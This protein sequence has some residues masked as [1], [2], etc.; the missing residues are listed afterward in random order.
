MKPR[1]LFLTLIACTALLMVRYSSE[2]ENR[3]GL[4][5]GSPKTDGKASEVDGTDSG[6]MPEVIVRL[7]QELRDALPD[8]QDQQQL[9]WLACN[10][11][12]T[13]VNIAKRHGLT[14]V[15]VILA[16]GQH[17]VAVMR[18][19]PDTF[20]KVANRLGGMTAA[21]FLVHLNRHFEEIAALGGLPK[22]LDRIESLPLEMRQLGT[23]HPEMLIFLACAPK[24]A[25]EALQEYPDL[26]LICFPLIDL[27][28]GPEPL[29][30]VAGM[31][32][33]HGVQAR[34]WVET[35][36]LDGMLLADTFPTVLDWKAPLDL[37]VFL[38][39][40]SNNQQDIQELIVDGREKDIQRSFAQL[41][42]QN[43]DLPP[44]VD[45]ETKGIRRPHRGD[46]LML[47]CVD[48]HTIRFLTES[49][50]AG[51]D[52][53][54]RTWP[55]AA[56]TGDMLPSLLYE[57]YSARDL[58]DLYGHA[59]ESLV[60]DGHERDA[61]Q[62]LH[63]MAERPGQDPRTVHPRSRRFRQLLSKHSARVVAYL[64][65]AEL[66]EGST[67]NRYRLLEDRGKSHLDAWD[68][69]ASWLVESLPL[70]DAVQLGCL[71]AQGNVPTK[72]EVAFAG[73]DVLFTAWDLATLGGGKTAS[74]S[75]KGGLKVAGEAGAERAS[76]RI[77][78]SVVGK[79]GRQLGEDAVEG[80]NRTLA[81]RM[82]RSPVVAMEIA[83]KKTFRDLAVNAEKAAWSAN[84]KQIPITRLAKY[85]IGEWAVNA[86]AG[87]SLTIVAQ[88]SS[89]TD[90]SFWASKAKEALLAI[91]K[92]SNASVVQ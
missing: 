23:K 80:L 92:F 31:I 75:V 30:R 2:S 56:G 65:E 71:L 68:T 1:L 63:M 40:L 53:L 29:E 14:G 3:E 39:I 16:L 91:D 43:R 36:G 84:L 58:P 74:A 12:N 11:G 26:C 25:Y 60:V 28:Q 62:M 57:A 55:E 44:A 6:S 81:N 72:G 38:E 24:S 33:R 9:R 64:A 67:E 8:F 77:A 79:A 17:G 83:T 41:E 88:W 42:E 76:R 90:N 69:P 50:N 34:S 73:I 89:R 52:V 78:K 35:R 87:G 54:A 46:W 51:Y 21:V 85:A 37:P 66:L 19:H 70:Y 18:E 82:S 49:G 45:E 22:L 27:S 5:G 48:P 4:T 32:V 10:Y 20:E 61:F 59:W 15:E 7:E 86:G 13:A 47:A